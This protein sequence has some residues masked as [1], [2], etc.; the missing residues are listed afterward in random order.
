MVPAYG[1][2]FPVTSDNRFFLKIPYSQYQYMYTIQRVCVFT[3]FCSSNCSWS[4]FSLFIMCRQVS[5]QVDFLRKF[6]VTNATH[7]RLLPSVAGQ[8]SFQFRLKQ[9]LFSTKLTPMHFPYLIN[10]LCTI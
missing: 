9:E 7:E 3:L 10:K 5:F 1:R 8:V 4:L 2:V 6:L